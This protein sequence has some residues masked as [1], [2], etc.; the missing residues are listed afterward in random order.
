MTKIIIYGAG[1]IY[2]SM[3]KQL[4][5]NYRILAFIED[6]PARIGSYIDGYKIISFNDIT[7]FDYDLVFNATSQYENIKKKLINVGIEENKIKNLLDY[8]KTISNEN[9]SEILLNYENIKI[10]CMSFFDRCAINE[11]FE[12]GIYKFQH[13]KNKIIIVDIGMHIGSASLFFANMPNVQKIYAYEPFN[14]TYKKALYNFDLNPELKNKI[15]PNNYGLGDISKELTL[16]YSQ[17]FSSSMSTIEEKNF[18]FKNKHINDDNFMKTNIKI[19]D[20]AN[21]L[22][23]LTKND[24]DFKNCG[25]I[26]KIDCEGYEKK[27]FNRLNDSKLLEKI[28]GFIVETHST[29]DSNFITKILNDNKF[30]CFNTGMKN[31]NCGML[32]AANTAIYSY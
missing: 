11:V 27:I 3:R 18:D 16:E 31:Y 25:I 30:I 4:N 23:E 1:N 20:I 8:D 28:D 6:N 13:F 10:S 24:D 21:E 9:G 2:M 14:N 15:I 26:I 29:D 22:N 5:N 7:S 32:Y 19:K 12:E 17:K